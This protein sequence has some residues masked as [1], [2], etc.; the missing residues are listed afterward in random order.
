MT[1][2]DYSRSI[3][4]LD[5]T[6]L[7]QFV[8]DWV[9]S[10]KSAHV[11]VTRFSG[12]GDLGR[13]VVI[14]LSPMKHE[15][16]WHNYQC[17]QYGK[18]LPTATALCE[19]GKI[20][21]YSWKGEFSVPEK[22]FFVAPRGVNRNLE[23]LIFNPSKLKE[24][25]IQQWDKYCATRIMEGH[26][27]TLD[28]DL[29]Q[30][31]RNFDFSTVGRL[32]LDDIVNDPTA[33]STLYKW[34]GADPGPAPLGEVPPSILPSELPYINQLV[35]AYGK[36][37]GKPIANHEDVLSFPGHSA[38]L[39]IQRER[40]Y[41]A[42][43]FK[44]FYRD[45]TDQLVISTFERDIFHGVV[46]TCNAK[47]PDALDRVNAVMAQAANLQPSGPL[48]KHARIPVKQ[49][50]CHHFANEDHLKWQK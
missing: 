26:S 45:N 10:K 7:E 8:R 48:A 31:I 29:E 50:I 30:L 40:F 28:T 24:E 21:Y 15:G 13:D 33:T 17:K 20:L 14:F 25:L 4:A 44:R 47:H 5:D 43:A 22:Y 34:F 42:D 19:L 23:T 3:L 1:K 16:A 46:D 18:T 38:H 11:T 39:S 9:D 6:E 41:D 27:I 12:T 37:E 36:R 2:K 35:N 32:N 49:G